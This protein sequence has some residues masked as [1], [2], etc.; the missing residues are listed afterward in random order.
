MSTL[1][2]NN[3]DN[4]GL[5]DVITNGVLESRALPSGSVLQVVS[6]TK[7]DT[8][9]TTS[10]GSYADITGLTATITPTS[11]SSNILVLATVSH[12]DNG[13]NSYHLRLARGGTGIAVGNAD[14][15]RTQATSPAFAVVASV[16]QVAHLSH[17]DS[18]ASTSALTYSVQLFINGGTKFINRSAS[19]SNGTE[20]FRGVSS[21][22]LMEIAG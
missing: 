22:T 18:P 6:T 2:V 19:D 20:S 3:I 15:S 17:L 12:G 8:F 21:I 14:G 9:S 13:S 10:A 1:R 7:T 11:T 5:D 4:L 16:G